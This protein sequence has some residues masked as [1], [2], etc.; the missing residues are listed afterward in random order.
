MPTYKYRCTKCNYEFEEFQSMTAQPLQT[1]PSCKNKSLIR[2]IGSG[3]GVIFKGSG[4]YLTDYKKTG[5]RKSEK[6]RK[7]LKEEKAA[8]AK[9]EKESASPKES[10]K[11]SKSEP[12]KSEE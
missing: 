8:L 7:E 5:N 9:A 11:P 1:C 6:G 12:S 2:V 4:F 3:G 10:G